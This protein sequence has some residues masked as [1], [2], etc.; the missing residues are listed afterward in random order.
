MVH[1]ELPVRI[2]ISEKNLEVFY[3]QGLVKFND[4]QSLILETKKLRSSD[5]N[6]LQEATP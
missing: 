5:M 6:N 4:L 1:L 2:Q 3:L